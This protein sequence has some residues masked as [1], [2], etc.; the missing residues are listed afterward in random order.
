MGE[1]AANRISAGRA[2]AL[3]HLVINLP[4]LVIIGVVGVIA[5]RNLSVGAGLA[6]TF[7][8]AGLAWLWWAFCVPRWRRWAITRGAD[9]KALQKL[10][11][12]TGLL[13]PQGSWMSRTEFRRRRP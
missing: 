9:P 6:L 1:R 8:A 12:M 11:L 10:G 4:A 3:G 2:V 7:G 13:W 5:V